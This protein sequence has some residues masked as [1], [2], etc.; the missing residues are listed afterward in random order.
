MTYHGENELRWAGGSSIFEVNIDSAELGE[1]FYTVGRG[2]T[3]ALT[4]AG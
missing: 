1:H 4:L 3:L 2:G